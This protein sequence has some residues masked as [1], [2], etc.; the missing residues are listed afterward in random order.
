MH[1][2]LDDCEKR[3]LTERVDIQTAVDILE[4]RGVRR[5]DLLTEITKVFYVDLD[6]FN[7]VLRLS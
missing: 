3:R 7:R 5:D 1:A 6:E 4:S 2:V